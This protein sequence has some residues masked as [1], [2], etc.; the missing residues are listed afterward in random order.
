MKTQC[1][2][3]NKPMHTHL[4]SEVNEAVLGNDEPLTDLLT[5][6]HEIRYTM[7]MISNTFADQDK[8]IVLLTSLREEYSVSAEHEIKTQAVQT[9][10]TATKKMLQLRV[11]FLTHLV[12]NGV[13][14]P[15]RLMACM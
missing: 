13:L 9:A 10:G 8:S 4:K 5:H 7:S 11:L 6:M 2:A 12:C 14:I 3:R 1:E 15:E